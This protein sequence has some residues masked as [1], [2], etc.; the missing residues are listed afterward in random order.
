LKANIT[1]G[2]GDISCADADR[3]PIVRRSSFSAKQMSPPIVDHIPPNS[4]KW[5]VM[6]AD[7]TLPLILA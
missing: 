6:C 4:S 3:T 5:L 2:N 7:Y 1:L